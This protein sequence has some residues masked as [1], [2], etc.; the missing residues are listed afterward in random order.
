LYRARI[1]QGEY[2]QAIE[3][4]EVEIDLGQ[5]LSSSFH[6]LDALSYMAYIDW[7]EKNF[8]QAI[9]HAKKALEIAVDLPSPYKK[10]TLYVL[11]RVALSQSDYPLTREYLARVFTKR[12]LP[13]IFEYEYHTIQALGVLATLQGQRRRAAVIFGALEALSGWLLNVISPAERDEYEQALT[14][15]RAELGEE[16]FTAAWEEGRSMNDE[17]IR[18]YVM[19]L[20][21]E[22]PVVKYMEKKIDAQQRSKAELPSNIPHSSQY[23]ETEKG[24]ES[25]TYWLPGKNE[26][27][28]FIIFIIQF[29]TLSCLYHIRPYITHGC[30]DAPAGRLYAVRAP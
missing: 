13:R 7:A 16:A 6:F 23:N 21:M 2:Q 25:G 28:R 9:L 24:R 15:T 14:E 8:G 26:L 29:P 18:Q 5:H 30:R 12:L 22:K 19:E 3:H 20:P 17:E 27:N 4:I 1:A 10:M 11:G